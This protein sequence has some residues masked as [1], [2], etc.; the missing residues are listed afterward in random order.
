[1]NM[2]MNTTMIKI[3]SG[4]PTDNPMITPFESPDE[5]STGSSSVGD[6]YSSRFKDA[7]IHSD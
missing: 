7:S 3:M 5:T 6:V 4:I 2:M 1:M